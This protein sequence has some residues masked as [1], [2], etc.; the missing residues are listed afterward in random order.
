MNGE[1][2][3]QGK[4]LR[5]DGSVYEGGWEEGWKHGC[6]ISTSTSGE[7]RVEEWRRGGLEGGHAW[8]EFTSPLLRDLPRGLELEGKNISSKRPR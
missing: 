2:Q 1:K 5:H 4:Q 3:G 8:D 7:Q 6:G